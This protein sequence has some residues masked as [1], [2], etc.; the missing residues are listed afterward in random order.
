MNFS[1]QNGY[2][3]PLSDHLCHLLPW[4]SVM[5]S[6][7]KLGVTIHSRHGHMDYF[8][9][10]ST[11]YYVLLHRQ[12]VLCPVLFVLTTTDVASVCDTCG[13]SRTRFRMHAARWGAQM[14]TGHAGVVGGA[15]SASEEFC[16]FSPLCQCSPTSVCLVPTTICP[17]QIIR[18][19]SISSA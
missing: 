16:T 15:L 4:R 14:P 13:N 5:P 19:P 3:Y 6:H 12:V 10:R 9:L 7:W 18:P 8:I 2:R 11:D 17:I 1:H